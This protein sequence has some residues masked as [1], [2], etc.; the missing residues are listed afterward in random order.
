MEEHIDLFQKI[1]TKIQNQVDYADIRA[2]KGNSNS[3]LM[4]DNKF[5]NIDSGISTG[6]GIRVLK[7][8]AWG[9]AYTNDISKLEE[10]TENAIK[11]SNSLTGEVEL[12]E[13]DI[14]EDKVEANSKI[15][16]SDI[17]IDEKKEL[18]ED[19]NKASNVGSVVS[20]TVSYSD[21]ESENFFINTEGSEILTENSRI[22]LSLN[23][24]ASNGELM[25][26]SHESLGGTKGYEILRNADIESFGRRIGEKATDLLDA[27]DRKSTRL[28][29]SH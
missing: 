20:T 1:I 7:N 5:Q 24:V 4:K 17:D 12:A 16:A 28:N 22:I 14:I 2:G 9:F 26:F 11:I 13:A 19:A 21:V 3:I 27:T 8:G 18:I 25:Q 15:K 29:S 23:A 10:I 6:A